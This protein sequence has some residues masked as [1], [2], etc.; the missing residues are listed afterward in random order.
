MK[1]AR[2]RCHRE[3]RRNR[4][5]LSSLASETALTQITYLFS[6][7]LRQNARE[8]LHCERSASWKLHQILIIRTGGT[9]ALSL[10]QAI[11][12]NECCSGSTELQ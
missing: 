11:D 6:N 10:I 1:H 12:S 7:K 4:T 3:R 9:T 2:E 5:S 8:S